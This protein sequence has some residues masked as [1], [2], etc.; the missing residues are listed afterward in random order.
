MMGK[1]TDS[2]LHVAAVGVLPVFCSGAQRCPSRG[3]AVTHEGFIQALKI[4]KEAALPSNEGWCRR[5]C[6]NHLNLL[7]QKMEQMRLEEHEE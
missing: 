4:R 7:M 2:L 5:I 3:P 1:S 6:I